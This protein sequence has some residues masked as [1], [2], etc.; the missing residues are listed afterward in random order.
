MSFLVTTTLTTSL[1]YL[2]ACK[3][4]FTVLGILTGGTHMGYTSLGWPK[5]G[6]ILITVTVEG[7]QCTK[8]GTCTYRGLETK[9]Y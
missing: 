5:D 8:L 3:K 9:N 2:T 1:M 4:G 6:A 7:L